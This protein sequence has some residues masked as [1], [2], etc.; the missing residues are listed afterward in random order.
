M[1]NR[2]KRI[3]TSEVRQTQAVQTKTRILVA[4]G[5][6]FQS[7]GFECVTIEKLAHA[8]EVSPPTIYSLFQSKRGVLRALIDEALPSDQY[9]ALVAEAHQEKSVKKRLLIAAKISRHLYDAERKQMNI[10]KSAAILAPEFKELEQER[11][12]RRY[13]RLERTIQMMATENSLIKGLNLSKIRDVLWAFTG[14]DLYRMLVIEQG[15][16]S[17]EYE[18]WLAQLLVKTLIGIKQTK[19]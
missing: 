14:R 19:S 6:L 13:Q 8:A 18:E 7:E 1:S 16:T 17:D 3:Y 12:R 5:K 11:E 4:A 9:E 15:W 2:K 10:F